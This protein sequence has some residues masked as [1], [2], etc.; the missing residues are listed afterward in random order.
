MVVVYCGIVRVVGLFYCLVMICVNVLCMLK[1]FLRGDQFDFLGIG[2][3][4]C[5]MSEFGYS[6][7]SSERR[8]MLVCMGCKVLVLVI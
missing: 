8:W 3:S 2:M 6:F 1:S 5:L 4:E 7:V